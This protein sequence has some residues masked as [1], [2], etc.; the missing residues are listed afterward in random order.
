MPDSF[1]ADL[2]ALRVHDRFG[3]SSWPQ[4]VVCDPR[5]GGIIGMPE[6]SVASVTTLFDRACVSVAG[7]AKNTVPGRERLVPE[8]EATLLQ[9]ERATAPETV[10]S[11]RRARLLERLIRDDRG[12]IVVRLRALQILVLTHPETVRRLAPALLL[13]P[14]DPFRYAVLGLLQ[15]RPDPALEPD[16]IR[17]FRGAGEEIQSLNPNVLRINTVR[18]LGS[19][20]GEEAIAAF[21]AVLSDPDPRNYLHRLLV[22]TLGEIGARGVPEQRR[23]VRD[24]L[25][26]AVPAPIPGEGDEQLRV[27]EERLALAMVR[28]VHAAL[29]RLLAREDLPAAPVRWSAADRS[30]WLQAVQR[31]I[32]PAAPR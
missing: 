28:S 29:S 30:A 32:G 9:V 20:G 13:V 23:R 8:L 31:A 5:D 24:V 25:L 27:T 17:L 19:G 15:N 1:L 4:M 10:L 3:I 14:N 22:E 11:G 12:D 2:E 7:T 16:L 6:R 21:A 26:T 18:A